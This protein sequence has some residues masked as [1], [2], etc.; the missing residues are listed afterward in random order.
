MEGVISIYKNE[1]AKLRCLALYDQALRNWPISFEEI[2]LDTNFGTTH[3]I[4]CGKKEAPP[5]VLL[6]GRWSTSTMWSPMIKELSIDYRVYAIDQIDDIGMSVLTRKIVNR[7]DYASWLLEVLTK[8]E[9]NRSSF[10]GLSYGGFLAVNFALVAPEKVKSI[11]LLS[12]G[13]PIFGAPTK[14]WALHG[15]PMTIFPTR[16]TAEWLV[17]GMSAKGYEKGKLEHEQLIAAVLCLRSRIPIQPNIKTGELAILKM[18]ILLLLGD[19]ETMYDPHTA[20][21]R[22]RQLISHLQAELIS[23]AGH[24]LNTDQPDLVMQRIME[25]LHNTD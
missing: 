6:H 21:K 10:I 20:I 25:F 12:P 13:L 2:K 4:V 7:S 15:I 23:N 18:P 1:R 24:M 17:E 5:I 11:C 16:K 8:L 19:K 9:I 14:T 22:A 3:S